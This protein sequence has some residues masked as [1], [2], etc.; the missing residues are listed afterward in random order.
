VRERTIFGLV[1]L[2]LVLLGLGYWAAVGLDLMPA[3][4][5]TRAV[6]VDNLFRFL[7]GV[8]TVIFL[9][10]EG[11]LIYAVLRFRH[12]PGDETDA[13]PVHGSVSLELVWTFIP[14]VIV[15]VVAVYSYQVLAHIER[16]GA[17]PRTVEVIARQF[18]WEFYYPDLDLSTTELHL[19][20][21]E[22]VRLMIRSEDVIHSFWVPEFRA[23]R[24]ATPGQESELVVVPNRMGTYPIRC[25]ELCGPG[26]AIMTS[27]VVV[28]TR[29]EFEEWVQ[30]QVSLPGDPVEAGRVLFGRYGCNACHTLSDAG[31]TGAVGPS[32]DGLGEAAGARR[33]GLS[34][35]EY[36]RES[37]LDPNAFIVPGFQAG[38]MPPNLGERLSPQELEIL[39]T[40]LLG[41]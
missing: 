21:D 7:L 5:A 25:A 24:D 2:S 17:N 38:L 14:A 30:N 41:N 4:A 34:A 23:K 15:T 3:Q 19:P 29:S 13:P 33:P 32:L 37:I 26:H 10:V 1:I 9:I 35:E 27:R 31:A 6:V 12:R 36:I 40:Y 22:P 20:V 18:S 16:P 11:A 39:V 8:A 28:Q